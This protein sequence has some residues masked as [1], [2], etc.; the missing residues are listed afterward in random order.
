MD[1]NLPGESGFTLCRK[2]PLNLKKCPLRE[3]KKRL[4]KAAAMLDIT[5]Q[6]DKFPRQ[7]SGGQRQRAACARALITEP[8]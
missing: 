8:R 7:L 6:L 5:E 1:V 3:T 4:A 2:L